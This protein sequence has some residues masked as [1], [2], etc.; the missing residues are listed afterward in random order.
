[1]EILDEFMEE[2]S[3]LLKKYSIYDV[4]LMNFDDKQ[5]GYHQLVKLVDDN[6]KR[7]L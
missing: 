2:F 7:Y 5:L 1:M 3:N 4:I 6:D